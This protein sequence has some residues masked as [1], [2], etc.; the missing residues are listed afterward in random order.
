MQGTWVSSLGGADPLEKEMTTHSRILAWE[1]AWT[2]EPGRLHTVHGVAKEQD[3][4]ERPNITCHDAIEVSPPSTLSSSSIL[5]QRPATTEVFNVFIVL[6]F[7]E[8]L[9]LDAET[10]ESPKALRD[11]GVTQWKKPGSLNDAHVVHGRS[12][13]PWMM[14]TLSE[15]VLDRPLGAICS[16]WSY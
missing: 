16:R 12:L 6:T 11:S 2:E 7:S 3:T 13:D 10:W 8:C 9:P 15:R 5:S 1:T 14:P 4:T